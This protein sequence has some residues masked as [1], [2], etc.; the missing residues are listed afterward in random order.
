MFV[1]LS[2][3]A[4]PALAGTGSVPPGAEL[5]PVR[6]QQPLQVLFPGPAHEGARV[7]PAGAWQVGVELNESNTLNVSRDEEAGTFI[8]LDFEVTRLT[9]DVARGLGSGWDVAVSVPYSARWGGVMDRPI[10]AVERVFD[11]L[12]PKR[13]ERP[14]NRVALGYVRDGRTVIPT[15]TRPE[16]GLGDVGLRIRKSF[17]CTGGGTRWAWRAGLELPT[18]DEEKVFGS[19]GTDGWTGVAV[20]TGHW[21]GR[22]VGNVNLV[23]PGE[24]WDGSGVEVDAFPTAAAAWWYPW[25][26]RASLS[27]QLGYYGSGFDETGT[28]EL[29]DAL[30]DLSV[31]LSVDLGSGWRWQLGGTQNLVY[32]PGAD[33][34]VTSRLVR[35]L[36]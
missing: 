28:E 9:V 21:G 4:I 15:R 8:A 18:G 11:Q 2:G 16:A 3:A 31:G 34:T 19:G 24:A 33:F 25:W 30:W 1:G 36:R 35:V 14:R 22:F 20:E 6:N 29:E 13:E 5:L 27:V 17:A 32:Q 10:E 12:N 7:L 23:L 26:P